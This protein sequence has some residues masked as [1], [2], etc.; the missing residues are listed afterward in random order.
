[1]YPLAL[2]STL[3]NAD[4]TCPGFITIRRFEMYSREE[5]LKPSSCSSSTTR[6]L[7]RVI[8][9]I[10]YPCRA[11]LY[12]WHEEYFTNGRNIPPTSNYL[13]YTEVQKMVAVDHFF[14]HGQCLARTTRLLEYP[15]KRVSYILDRRCIRQPLTRHFIL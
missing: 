10:R 1:M 2:I 8:R 3:G 4:K 5:K 6:A 9:E 14:E 15:F 11:I 12:A 13:R 7:W